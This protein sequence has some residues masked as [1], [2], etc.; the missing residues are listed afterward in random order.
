[1][2]PL[3]CLRLRRRGRMTKVE[4]REVSMGTGASSIALVTH[5]GNCSLKGPGETM[6]TPVRPR[7]RLQRSNPEASLAPPVP[8]WAS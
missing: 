7:F 8:G 4:P 5:S 2:F 1:M 6:G 3:A